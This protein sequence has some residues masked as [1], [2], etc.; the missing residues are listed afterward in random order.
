MTRLK[1]SETPIS[2]NVLA[3][4][5]GV[6]RQTVVKDISELKSHGYDIISTTRG[7]VIRQRP[8]PRRVFKVVHSDED[9]ENELNLIVNC[10][11]IVSDV[12]VWHKI[13]GKI[14]ATL[15]IRTREDV[16]EYI[17]SLK[18]GRSKPLKN[19]TN[20]YHYHTVRAED[21]AMLD[22][23]EYALSRSGFLVRED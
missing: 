7:Y 22:K 1:S 11:C 14:E 4:E 9:T 15:N 23:A 5:F 20:Q 21:E 19:V 12:F 3:A 17:R 8:M 16:G 18:S 13:Y 2:G 6:T 10:G